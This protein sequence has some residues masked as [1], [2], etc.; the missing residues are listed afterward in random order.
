MNKQNLKASLIS[1]AVVLCVA[2]MG[3][4]AWYLYVYDIPV[5]DPIETPV[6]EEVVEEVEETV[7]VKEPLT[8]VAV[9]KE[10]FIVPVKAGKIVRPFFSL[11]KSKQEQIDAI[12]E[13]DGVYR[14]NYGVDYASDT[15]DVLAIA[16]GEVKEVNKDTLFGNRVVVICG[17]Y[18]VTY[19]SMDEITVKVGESVKQGSVIGTMGE[20]V[21]DS[22]L[23]KHVHVIVE[24]N[25]KYLDL[26][27][28]IAKQISIS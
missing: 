5:S 2:T 17:Q 27:D 7:E 18:T 1:A 11:S 6:V 10:K 13:Y 3:G 4:Y 25:G 21:Y 28:L 24:V 23:G 14:S 26:E 15:L 20:N 12:I 9:V 19:Q 8:E 16:S 22:T